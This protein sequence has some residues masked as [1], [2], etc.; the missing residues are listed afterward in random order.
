[1]S[2]RFSYG[3]LEV[4]IINKKVIPNNVND[5]LVNKNPFQGSHGD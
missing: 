2:T 1:M 5:D 4:S 3:T